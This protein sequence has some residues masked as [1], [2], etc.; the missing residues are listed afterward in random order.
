MCSNMASSTYELTT[1]YVSE[2]ASWKST[3]LSVPVGRASPPSPHPVWST[4]GVSI[5]TC[6]GEWMHCVDNGIA[7]TLLVFFGI[8]IRFSLVGTHATKLAWLWGRQHYN[9]LS[10]WKPPNRTASCFIGWWGSGFGESLG[11]RV[12]QAALGLAP[13]LA[14]RGLPY[15]ACAILPPVAA[16]W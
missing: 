3:I 2:R 1:R 11:P 14:A 15:D 8:H 7:Q 10:R 4:A 16:Q 9:M 12:S 13:T 5:C 6:T